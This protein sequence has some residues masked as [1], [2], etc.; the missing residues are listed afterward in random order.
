MS[1]TPDKSVRSPHTSAVLT[2]TQYFIR[3]I[4]RVNRVPPMIVREV[5]GPRSPETRPA[6]APPRVPVRY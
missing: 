1:A 6:P 5:Q 4:S 2:R 3:R